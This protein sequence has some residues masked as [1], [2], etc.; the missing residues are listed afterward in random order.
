M[1]KAIMLVL[2]ATIFASCLTGCGGEKDSDSNLNPGKET[3]TNKTEFSEEKF[4][5]TKYPVTDVTKFNYAKHTKK[6]LEE[7]YDIELNTTSEEC[8]VVE[9]YDNEDKDLEVVVVPPEIDGLPV[10]AVV[11]RSNYFLQGMSHDE[12]KAVVLPD[13]V[14]IIAGHFAFSAENLETVHMGNGLKCLGRPSSYDDEFLFNCPRIKELVFPDSLEKIGDIMIYWCGPEHDLKRMYFPEGIEGQQ[15]SFNDVGDKN[16]TESEMIVECPSGSY[17]EICCDKEYIMCQN[18]EGTRDLENYKQNREKLSKFYSQ[19]TEV[20][21]GDRFMYVNQELGVAGLMY[22]EDEKT[23]MH[24]RGNGFHEGTIGGMDVFVQ[25]IPEEITQ[26][27]NATTYEGV[28]KMAMDVVNH[29]LEKQQAGG[30][31]LD[32]VTIDSGHGPMTVVAT[33]V[34]EEIAGTVSGTDYGDHYILWK[35]YGDKIIGIQS[36]YLFARTITPLP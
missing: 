16:V 6:E 21:N 20:T 36:W 34:K 4:D 12:V 14:E 15:A 19:Y 25:E 7:W 18:L 26:K 3:Q 30:E 23:L 28:E 27:Y 8:I 2:A 11:G 1:K 24:D 13:T 22:E 9:K 17:I 31:I 35:V 29:A 10:V 33:G 32:Y 5:H